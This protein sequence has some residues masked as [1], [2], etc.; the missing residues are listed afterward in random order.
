ML[1]QI[2]NKNPKLMK[3]KLFTI[4][5]LSL[6][7]IQ[8]SKAQKKVLTANLGHSS[9]VNSVAFSPDGKY[10]ATGSWDNTVKLWN[11]QTGQE[12]RTFEGHTEKV[13]SV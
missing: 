11:S 9:L 4:I 1:E 5:V 13:N 10:I 3:L 12:I 7:F 2:K 8:T 6:V